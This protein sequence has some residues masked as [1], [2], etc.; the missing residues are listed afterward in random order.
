MRFVRATAAWLLSAAAAVAAPNCTDGD[1]AWIARACY[2]EP[3][4]S[5]LYGHD[6]LGGTPE[7]TAVE[8]TLGPRGR[9]ALGGSAYVRRVPARHIFEDIA[10]RVVQLDGSGPPELI[11]IY[12]DFDRGAALMVDN[13]ET[14]QVSVTPHIGTRNRWLAPLGAVDLDG[15][16]LVELAYIDRPHLAKTLV[17]WRYGPSG[18]LTRVAELSGLTNHRIG[19]DFITGGIYVCGQGPAILSVDA[20]WRNVMATTLADGALSTRAVG[21]FTGMGA[22]RKQAGC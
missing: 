2:T 4:R 19:Q 14:G 1:G 22:M 21:P 10:P 9:T 16:G 18:Q 17:V 5:G 7:W 15:D 13:L 12:T 6:V 20:D 8:V 3:L 11:L